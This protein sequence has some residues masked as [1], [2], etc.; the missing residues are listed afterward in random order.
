[1][2]VEITILEEFGIPSDEADVDI[3]GII[4]TYPLSLAEQAMLDDAIAAMQAEDET[5]RGW[6]IESDK[7]ET[8][9]SIV[10]KKNTIDSE[11]TAYDKGANVFSDSPVYVPLNDLVTS[12]LNTLI[13]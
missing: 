8:Y 3:N 7:D 6:L 9:I 11:I 13:P 4:S 10:F 2:I 1:M 12:I 5:N